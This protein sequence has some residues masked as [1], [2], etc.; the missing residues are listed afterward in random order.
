MY[1]KMAQTCHSGAVSQPAGIACKWT[2]PIPDTYDIMTYCCL[3]QASR[4]SIPAC[5]TPCNSPIFLKNRL[6]TQPRPPMARFMKY[7]LS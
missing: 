5:Q 2:K 6:P 7:R 4:L 1:A 3:S